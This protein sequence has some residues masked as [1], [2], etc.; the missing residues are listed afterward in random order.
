M[1]IVCKDGPLKGDMYNINVEQGMFK[2][3][4]TNNPWY[5]YAVYSIL[6]LQT[7]LGERVA[8][9]IGMEKRDANS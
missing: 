4:L 7:P 2:I 5:K 8:T 1:I 6:P 3:V 9:F